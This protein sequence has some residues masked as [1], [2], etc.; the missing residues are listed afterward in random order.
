MKTKKLLWQIIASGLLVLAIL[1]MAVPTSAASRGSQ[2]VSPPSAFDPVLCQVYSPNAGMVNVLKA[3]SAPLAS[4]D[5]QSVWAVGY[6]SH[7]NSLN[8]TTNTLIMGYNGRG[9]NIVPS[10]NVSTENYLNSVAA[11]TSRD[12]WAVGYAVQNGMESPLVLRFTGAYWKVVDL[13]PGPALPL[14]VSTRLNS[15]VTFGTDAVVAL[16]YTSY[17]SDAPQPLAMYFDG[18]TWS[19]MDIPAL[20]KSG[21]IYGAASDGTVIWAVGSAANGITGDDAILYRYDGKT[22]SAI[23][24]GTGY[25]TSVALSSDGVFVVGDVT[26]KS[27]KETLAMLYNPASGSF[28]RVPSFNLDLDHNFL[29]AVTSNGREVYAVGYAGIPSN[30]LEMA[31]L[32]LRYNGTTFTPLQTPHPSM[33]DRLEGV[34]FINNRMWAVGSSM[35]GEFGRSTL[36]LSNNCATD[37]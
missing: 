28:D 14:P 37:R 34:A 2:G 8:P 29:T 25:L 11:R 5:S 31:P 10:P 30:D 16:G 27:G 12:A 4:S 6:V 21:K 9:W 32:V 1:G 7:P 22:W 13:P 23:T 3:V 20:G 18:K 33:V 17:A 19:K 15:V 24:K 36:V 35:K 26:G